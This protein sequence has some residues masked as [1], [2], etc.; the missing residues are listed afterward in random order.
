MLQLTIKGHTYQVQELVHCLECEICK[1]IPSQPALAL[2]CGQVI[3]CRSCFEQ[4]LNT[5][6]G[7]AHCVGQ[8]IHKVSLLMAM[9]VSTPSCTSWVGLN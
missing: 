5:L 9:R 3:G 7:L 2:C 4:C 6:P 1:D 8:L